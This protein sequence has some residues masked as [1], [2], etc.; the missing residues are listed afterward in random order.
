MSNNPYH[1]G[2]FMKRPLSWLIIFCMLLALAFA[3]GCGDTTSTSGTGSQPSQTEA[4]DNQPAQPNNATTDTSGQDSQPATTPQPAPPGKLRI[5][6][7][8]VGQGDSILIQTPAG[9]AILIDAG[10]NAA[11]GTVEAY[12]QAQG[13]KNID[14]V[15]G[16]H[17]H[18]DHIGGLD[19]VIRNFAIGEVY[20]PKVS[21][22]TVTFTNLLQ[23][24]KDKGLKVTTAKGGV[25]LDLGPGVYAMFLAPNVA[26][27]EDL[28][29]YS[30]VLK[31]AYG[32]STFL[33]EGDAEATSESQMV[34]GDYDL[35]IDV[36]KVGH[37]GSTSSSSSAF[38]VATTPKYAVISVEAGNTY[39]HPKDSTLQALQN[40]GTKIYRTD[41]A[42]TIVV[43]SDGKNISINKNASVIKP[44]APNKT[45]AGGFGAVA[46]SVTGSANGG[47]YIGNKNT[48]KFHL[49]SCS[50]LPNPENRVYFKTRNEAVNAGYVPCKRCNP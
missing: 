29:D 18:E 13:I 37:H 3:A 31:L 39:G 9:K 36:L 48:H 7:I 12:L 5:H 10:P 50:T 8:D 42:G 20:L 14:V 40:V 34:T 23:E 2:V 15:I 1:G 22:T 30:A 47:Q 21:H 32:N 25:R 46:G 33:F 43:E 44:R 4:A 41:E 49:P 19:G 35:D 6:F 28:N 24:I 27:Y 16:T 11:E 38:L 45:S 17:P 26:S